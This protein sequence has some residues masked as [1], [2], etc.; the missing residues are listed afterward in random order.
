MIMTQKHFIGL[1]LDTSETDTDSESLIFDDVGN[2]ISRDE[3]TTSDLIV[4]NY[5]YYNMLPI[6]VEQADEVACTLD[7]L[8]KQRK[9][10]KNRIFYKY[11]QGVL[12]VHFTPSEYS[13]D[14]AVI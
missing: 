7:K 8:I 14:P 12:Q 5:A 10:S 3:D 13:W 11:L 2:E 4:I 1:D 6:C 9:I